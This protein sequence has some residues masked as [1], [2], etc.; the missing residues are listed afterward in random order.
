MHRAAKRAILRNPH[1]AYFHYVRAVNADE[2]LDGLRCITKGLACPKLT[3]CTK[4]SLWLQAAQHSFRLVSAHA[5]VS[6]EREMFEH[7]NVMHE[8]HEYAKTALH[9]SVQYIKVAGTGGGMVWRVCALC[10]FSWRVCCASRH[11]NQDY[12]GLR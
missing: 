2:P 7:F 6:R 1:I 3:K 8:L 12:L 10:A 9:C 5:R 4:L 11:M